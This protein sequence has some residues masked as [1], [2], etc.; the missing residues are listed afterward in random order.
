MVEAD[1]D[2]AELAGGLVPTVEKDA[3]VVEFGNLDFVGLV[4]GEGGK[5]LTLAPGLAAIGGNCHV[6]VPL[7]ADA[8]VVGNDDWAL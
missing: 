8:L 1:G 2:Q 7:I 3:T 6:D 5:R 4:L